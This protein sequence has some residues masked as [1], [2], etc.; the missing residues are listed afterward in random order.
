MLGR[1]VFEYFP[2]FKQPYLIFLNFLESILELH[3]RKILDRFFIIIFFHLFPELFC[4]F[5]I[6]LDYLTWYYFLV[7]LSFRFFVESI[8]NFAEFIWDFSSISLHELWGFCNIMIFREM[9]KKRQAWKK[10]V[11]LYSQWFL[12][13]CKLYMKVKFSKITTTSDST[14]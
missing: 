14:S 10:W 1:I 12:T 3:R 4:L 2:W 11:V 9:F 5:V 6:F 8:L 13:P 7:F